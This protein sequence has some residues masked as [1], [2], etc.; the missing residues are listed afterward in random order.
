MAQERLSSTASP[1]A[2]PTETLQPQLAPEAQHS[3]IRYEGRRSADWWPRNS[4]G[5]VKHGTENVVSNTVI[6]MYG[7]QRVLE[8]SGGTL[9]KSYDYLIT[10]PYT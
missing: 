5:D 4:H 9:G 6:T 10:M 7:A 8:M 2:T 3:E 1:G